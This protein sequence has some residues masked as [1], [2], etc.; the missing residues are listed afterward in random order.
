MNALRK[1]PPAS[2]PNKGAVHA[3][4]DGQSTRLLLC[5]WERGEGMKRGEADAAVGG[6]GRKGSGGGG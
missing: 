4:D 1:A 3:M 2:Q 5:I 6:V